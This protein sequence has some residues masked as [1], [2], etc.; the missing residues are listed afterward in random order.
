MLE[1]RFIAVPPQLFTA[2]G[3]VNGQVEVA[4]TSLFKVKQQVVVTAAGQINLEL[5]IKR[6]DSPT[7]MYVGPKTGNID[8]RIDLT[9]YTVTAT[10]F[11]FANEQKRPSIPSEEFN[12]AVY[13]EEPVVAVRTILV[14]KLG[15]KYSINNPLPVQLS[16]GAINIGSV[17][18]E[19]EVQLSHKDNDPN[20]GDIHDS[21][22]VGDGTN[23]LHVNTDGSLNVNIVESPTASPPLAIRYNEIT[24]VPTGSETTLISIGGLMNEIRVYAIDVSGTNKAT[25]KL[26]L[27]G[28]TIA[29]KR[30]SFTGYNEKFTFE[31]FSN[32][33]K[34]DIGDQLIITVQHDRPNLGNFEATL[35]ST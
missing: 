31:P 16:D 1:K 34:V 22:R 35:A 27:N 32:G 3:N 11:I 7:T 28:S 15:D 12:R 30:T 2:D 10:A 8:S 4:D 26:K 23:E 20:A 5:E 9:G 25:Y 6:I 33:L 29:I 18:A 21:V 14:D 19:L 17:N 13:E 24:A